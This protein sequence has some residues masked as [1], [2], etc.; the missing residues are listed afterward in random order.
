MTCS[1]SSTART[2]L[3]GA[4]RVERELLEHRHR[5]GAVGHA[6]DQDA[7]ARTRL[8]G[9][10]RDVRLAL[11]VVGEDLQ[12][13]GQVDLAHVDAVG[14]RQHGRREVQD[15]ADAGRDQPVAD[16]LGRDR[17]AWRSTPIAT[18]CSAHD[19]LEL[20][21]G[22]DRQLADP[23]ADAPGSLSS[24]ATTRKPREAKPE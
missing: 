16:V 10:A 20:V 4:R 17:R 22:R 18:P 6:D 9:R 19:L 14:H 5:G 7:H 15:A 1:V 13:D 21:E 12:L 3:V 23:L 24:S 11:L 8:S 2:Q